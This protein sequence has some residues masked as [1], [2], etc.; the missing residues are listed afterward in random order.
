MRLSK[1]LRD[2]REGKGQTQLEASREVGVHQQTWSTWERGTAPRAYRTIRRLADW[3]GI[4][5]EELDRMVE[6][7]ET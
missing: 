1:Y 7:A 3:A 5:S 4:T 2:V 6:Q